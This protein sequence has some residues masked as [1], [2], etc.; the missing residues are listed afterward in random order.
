MLEYL[1]T[2]VYLLMLHI[3]S[4]LRENVSTHILIP[5]QDQLCLHNIKV[6]VLCTLWYIGRK[7]TTEPDLRT[8]LNHSSI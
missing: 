3:H 4:G 8:K 1:S 6:Y 7:V 2:R 5:L